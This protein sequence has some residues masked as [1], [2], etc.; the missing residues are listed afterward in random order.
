MNRALVRLMAVLGTTMFTFAGCRATAKVVLDDHFD[1][2]DPLTN[3]HG[4]GHGWYRG[5]RAKTDEAG[6]SLRFSATEFANAW[7]ASKE[8][9]NFPF[10]NEKG[11]TVTWRIKKTDVQTPHRWKGNIVWYSLEIV[12]AHLKN[13]V[14]NVN[15]VQGGMVIQV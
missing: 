14:T 11:A 5:G 6:S 3:S 15:A 12:S 9:D 1:D 4:V 13:S 8:A 10:W 2:S 7:F